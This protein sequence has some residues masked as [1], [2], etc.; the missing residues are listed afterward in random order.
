MKFEYKIIEETEN[1]A[2]LRGKWNSLITIQLAEQL[3]KV[4]YLPLQSGF[5]GEII[6]LFVQKIKCT[7]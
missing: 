1:F 5:D 3:F 7:S 6:N 4:G 2:I